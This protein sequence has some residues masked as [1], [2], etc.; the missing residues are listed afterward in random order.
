[1]IDRDPLVTSDE[2]RL[3]SQ[4][5]YEEAELLDSMDYKTWLTV[6][7]PEI[8]YR[9]LNRLTRERQ[10]NVSAFDPESYLVRCNRASLEARVARVETGWAFSE[11]PP[12]ITRRFV[13]NIR[14]QRVSNSEFKDKSSLLMFRARFE[15]NAFVSALR[16]DD[17][18]R[19]GDGDLHLTRRWIYIDHT[20]IPVENFSV[21]L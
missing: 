11:D 19:D 10:G 2:W 16:D 9:V 6:I 21:A 13:T 15:E 17:W 5:L 1:M 8:D 4:R 20:V 14:L 3:C 12:A 7:G 18:E